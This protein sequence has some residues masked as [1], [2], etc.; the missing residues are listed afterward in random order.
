MTRRRAACT[1]CRRR[2]GRAFSDGGVVHARPLVAA[3]GHILHAGGEV[4]RIVLRQADAARSPPHRTGACTR[5]ARTRGCAGRHRRDRHSPARQAAC[6]AMQAGRAPVGAHSSEGRRLARRRRTGRRTSR[7]AS[8]VIRPGGGVSVAHAAQLGS[9]R[10]GLHHTIGPE[11]RADALAPLKL[12]VERDTPRL[13]MASAT[14]SQRAAHARR[15]ARST[16]R[17]RATTRP[18]APRPSADATPL[19]QL[20][21]QCARPV[22][23]PGPRPTTMH[24]SSPR[25]T[26]LPRHSSASIR[27]SSWVFE[28]RCAATA[29]AQATHL[30]RAAFPH[31]SAPKPDGDDLVGR[32]ER[33]HDSAPA[34]PLG[35]PYRK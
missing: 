27:G 32:V 26:R 21:W 4:L 34:H 20:P 5:G 1:R 3:R 12:V 24:A 17:R 31:A 18:R 9:S 6:S 28:A 19:A 10:L 14:T 30:H 7:S 22:N 33:K 23:D 29:S 8:P 2:Q 35:E 11:S 16:P 15:P 13:R 25:A